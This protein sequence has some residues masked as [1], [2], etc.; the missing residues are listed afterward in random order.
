MGR[1]Y[2][3]VYV[4]KGRK[5]VPLLEVLATLLEREVNVRLVH[6]KEFCPVFR[7]DFDKYPTTVANLHR[8]RQSHGSG[9]GHEKCTAPQL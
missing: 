8:G 3:D 9:A 2:K 7:E 1:G 6:A 4:K 5:A